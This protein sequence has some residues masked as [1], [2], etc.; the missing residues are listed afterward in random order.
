[1]TNKQAIERIRLIMD[2]R[3]RADQMLIKID[4]VLKLVSE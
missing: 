2:M 4:E 1:M 3:I